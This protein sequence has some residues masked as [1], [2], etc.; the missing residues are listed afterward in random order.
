MGRAQPSPT[1]SPAP[2]PSQTPT[3]AAG[4][5]TAVVETPAPVR[6]GSS[7]KLDDA[8]LASTDE[9]AIRAPASAAS[10]IE[11]LS[12][13]LTSSAQ[14]DIEKARAIYRWITENIAYNFE[15]YLAKQYGDQSAA[16]V[17]QRRTAVCAGYANLFEA[18]GKSAGLEVV[19]VEGWSKGYGYVDDTLY[20]DPNHAW[21]AVSLGG[22]WYLIE[23]TWGSGFI[24]EEKRFVRRFESYYFL[25]PPE[26][27]IFT[28][29]P[30]DPRW[31]L[32]AGSLTKDQF[33]SSPRVWPQFFEDGLALLSNRSGTINA[34]HEVAVE[35]LTPQ[36][37]LLSASLH[38]RGEKLPDLYTFVHRDGPAY[39]IKAAFPE[40]GEYTL[41]LYSKKAGD[42][43]PYWSA[44]EYSVVVSEG[45]S[46]H[47][48]FPTVWQPFFDNPLS[49]VSH[50]GGIIKV[51]KDVEVVIGAPSD[52][53]VS[54]NL[55]QGDT[56]LPEYL[57]FVRRDG[58]NFII[59]AALPQA[60][61]YRLVIYSKP[62][63]DP[64][65]YQSSVEYLVVVSEGGPDSSGF[66]TVWQPFF[67]NQLSLV[68]H[69]GGIIEVARDVNVTIGA[70]S[71]VLLLANLTQG[72]AELSESLTFVQREGENYSIRAVF[73]RAGEYTLAIYSKR[74]SDP[75]QYQGSLEYIVRVSEGIPSTPGF[76]ATYGAFNER[77]AVLYAPFDGALA[78]GSVQTFRVKVPEAEK[79]A[80]V[81]GSAWTFLIPA[82]GGLFEGQVT[83]TGPDV[84]LYAKFPGDSQFTGLLSYRGK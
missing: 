49:L 74:A 27:L 28:H 73:P 40:A 84:V 1:P 47:P 37:A 36:D 13:Y 34:K 10:S 61:D 45:D 46:D 51:A 43:G 54:A 29:Y 69:P 39:E 53:L 79:V 14:N 9:L 70:P 11:S 6:A 19:V 23:S 50:T 2:R 33:L 22:N 57:T 55:M 76:P 82:G 26:Q 65:L 59:Q 3:A 75:G 63:S 72:G 20:G 4:V 5:P 8:R 32:L 17:L 48:G 80:V 16:A 30:L 56:E 21:N 64:G 18:L 67:E 81:I 38:H 15:G 78:Q 12:S 60:G 24:G 77:G 66:P 44:L 41:T 62:S 35:V 68:S 42:E 71:D 52:I 7:L 25:V 58:G 31:Q 83:I